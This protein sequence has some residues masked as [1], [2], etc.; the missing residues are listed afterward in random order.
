MLWAR[1][2]FCPPGLRKVLSRQKNLKIADKMTKLD[3]DNG[4]TANK[5]PKISP[6]K[7]IVGS[8]PQN[9]ST[10]ADFPKFGFSIEYFR[11]AAF[12]LGKSR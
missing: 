12:L 7:K 2:A 8:S 1:P 5:W 6:Q 10:S 11:K 9:R 4:K 3:Q